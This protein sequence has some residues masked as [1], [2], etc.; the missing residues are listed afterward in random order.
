[1]IAGMNTTVRAMK[2]NLFYASLGGVLEFYDFIIFALY[3]SYISAAFFPSHSTVSGILLTFTVF[4]SGYLARP[5]GGIIFGHFG[6][7]YGRKATFTCSIIIMA[8]STF[9]I[10][11]VPGYQ[12]IGVVAPLLLTLLRLAQGVSIGGEIPGA[13]TFVSEMMPRHRAFGCAAVFFGLISGIILGGFINLV[14]ESMFAEAAMAAYGWRMAFI[15][16]GIFGIWGFYLRR[17]LVETPIFAHL[18]DQR[19][20]KIPFTTLL[21]SYPLA[22]ISG[23][24]LCGLVSSAIMVLFLYIPAYAKMLE[25]PD[26]LGGQ[27][28]TS[29]LFAA[30]FPMLLYAWWGDRFSKRILVGFSIVI[31]LIFTPMLFQTLINKDYSLLVFLLFDSF[32]FSIITGLVPSILADSFPAEIR[33]SGVGLVYNLSFATTGGLAP[34]IMTWFINA[35]GNMLVPAYYFMIACALGAVG[36]VFY[37][38]NYIQIE[39][40]TNKEAS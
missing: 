11:C 2:R 13:V 39:Q 25:L 9:L 18:D 38:R 36:I 40:G 24:C 4:S 17:K 21:R 30:L 15:I 27:M 34:V 33:Y 16:G 3:A 32:T 31:A 20:H 26:T 8:V 14:L 12:S 28:N 29:V 1:M 10:A 37:P 5:L 7:K 35:T 22:L 23:W 19:R 6:D